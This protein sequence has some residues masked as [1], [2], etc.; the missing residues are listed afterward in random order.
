MNKNLILGMA[1]VLML[2]LSVSMALAKQETP[3]A[4]PP[5]D[6]DNECQDNGFDYGIV[7]FDYE[8]GN[9]VET[10]GSAYANYVIDVTGDSSSAS[11]TAV[12]GVAGVLRKASIDTTVFPGGVSGGPIG[13]WYGAAGNGAASWHGISHLTFC[14]N[15]NPPPPPPPCTGGNCNGVP[16]FGPAALVAAVLGVGLGLALLRKH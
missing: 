6:P 12:P 9:W 4:D 3:K 11:W 2:V 14:G 13:Q 1:M 10:P 5:K 7:K 16:E 15:G 8:G